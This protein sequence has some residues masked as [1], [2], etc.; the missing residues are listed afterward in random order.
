MATINSTYT[1]PDCKTV[2]TPW[3]LSGRSHYIECKNPDCRRHMIT[4]TVEHWLALTADE[5]ASFHAAH[6]DYATAVSRKA[7]SL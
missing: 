7:A 1:C 4:S 2:C 5:I 3:T 6:T